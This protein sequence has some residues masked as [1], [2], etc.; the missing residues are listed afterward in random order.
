MKVLV[1]EDVTRAQLAY[2]KLKA[3]Q[4]EYD[5][6]RRDVTKKYLSDNIDGWENGFEF[7]PDFKFI[8]PQASPVIKLNNGCYW[9]YGAVPVANQ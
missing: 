4:A 5:Q 6:V 1:P 2:Q 8:V 3:S 7:T 9:N